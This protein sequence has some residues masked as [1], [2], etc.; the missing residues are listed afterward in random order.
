MLW[1]TLLLPGARGSSCGWRSAS[2]SG[3]P[4]RNTSWQEHIL[5]DM[6]SE[7]QPSRG[8]DAFHPCAVEPLSVIPNRRR[9]N[10]GD[11]PA[12]ARPATSRKR[13]HACLDHVCSGIGEVLRGRSILC[14][15]PRFE[16]V[17]ATFG[18]CSAEFG[19]SP[20]RSPPVSPP[21]SQALRTWTA[22]Q[23]ACESAPNRARARASHRPRQATMHNNRGRPHTK[24]PLSQQKKHGR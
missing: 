3:R 22:S 8:K 23:A 19:S 15:T 5:W 20:R 24:R 14:V 4:V 1:A 17:S 13:R 9:V 10:A 7:V 21:A 6:F 18:P 11:P 16:P 12:S 2:L